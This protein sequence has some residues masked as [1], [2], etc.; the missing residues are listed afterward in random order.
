MERG[1]WRSHTHKQFFTHSLS[2][3]QTNQFPFL[4]PFLQNFLT[5]S[6]SSPGSVLPL[7]GPN[8]PQSQSDPPQVD[9]VFNEILK[10]L[11][12]LQ[13]QMRMAPDSIEYVSVQGMSL[14]FMLKQV[15]ERFMFHGRVMMGIERSGRLREREIEGGE[16]EGRRR[17]DIAPTPTPTPTPTPSER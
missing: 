4:F 16:G 15:R 2:I 7:G 14:L 17:N 1:A 12:K 5:L 11:S 10:I 9:Q 6:A 3:S 13:I 8:S